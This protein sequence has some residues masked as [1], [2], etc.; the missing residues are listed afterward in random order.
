MKS[1]FVLPLKLNAPKGIDTPALP[2]E[3]TF[4]SVETKW[5]KVRNDMRSFLENVDDKYL[6]KEVYKHPFAGRLTLKGMMSF[7]MA[8]FRHH[9]KQIDRAVKNATI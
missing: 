7:F 1:Y 3:D 8:H 5:Q 2:P 6:D 9:R 4:E